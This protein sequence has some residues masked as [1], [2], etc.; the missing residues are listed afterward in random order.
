M[1]E[2]IPISILITISKYF[3]HP[4]LIHQ[5]DLSMYWFNHIFNCQSNFKI[6]IPIHDISI[7]II[8][9]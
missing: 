8:E 1:I 6:I 9:R 3:N 5:F 2:D 4:E 7:E